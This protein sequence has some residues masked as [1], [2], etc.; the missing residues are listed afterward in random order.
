MAVADINFD[1]AERTGQR[2]GA[3]ACR[4]HMDVM[5]DS[6]I[7]LVSIAVPTALHFKV[8]TDALRAR[9]H[10]LVEKPIASTVDEA[11]A[12]IRTARSSGV[13]FGVGHVE[14][15]NP[16]ISATKSA[17]DAGAIGRPLQI[18]IRRIGPRPARPKDVG[19]FLDLA[20]HD[21]DIIR[22]LTSEDISGMSAESLKLSPDGVEDAAVGL[23]KLASGTVCT[24]IE[25]WIS[26]T[27]IR[28]VTIV[29]ETGMLVADTLTQDL[30]QYDN[31]YAS[32]DWLAIQNLRGMTD[33]RMVRH[34][35]PKGEPLRIELEHFVRSIS[36]GDPFPVTGEEGLR[37]LEI[38]IRLRSLADDT[39]R[40][41]PSN[42]I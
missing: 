22:Y 42:T 31:D 37:A 34:R 17:L 5:G 18:I 23:M 16:V 38:S 25:N 11:L 36:S 19:V 15:F 26:P 9:K 39:S 28:D 8:A 35:L 13:V 29:G 40:H 20:T 3:R 6:S 14:R 2:Y 21:I 41:T 32:T 30:Y 10:V 12:L 24:I 4:N 33:G 27:K 7:D 1:L